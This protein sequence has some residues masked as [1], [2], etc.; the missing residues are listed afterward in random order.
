MPLA[1]VEEAVVEPT[2]MVP[3]MVVVAGE[4]KLI[5]PVAVRLPLIVEEAAEMKPPVRVERLVTARVLVATRAEVVRVL[6][7]KVR[8]VFWMRAVPA[9][10]A[11]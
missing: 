11:Y 2:E 4:V 1:K 3:A 8:L 9:P 6:P 10:L 7:S 5:R